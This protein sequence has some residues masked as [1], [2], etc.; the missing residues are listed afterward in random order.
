MAEDHSSGQTA[1]SLLKRWIKRCDDYHDHKC[2][3]VP[4]AE[5]PSWKVPD[6]V[7]DT[8]E[9]CIVA[10][11]SVAQYAALS[12]VWTSP[13]NE[14]G[15]ATSTPTPTPDRLMLRSDNLEDFKRSGFLSA[16]VVKTLPM[17]VRDALDLVQKSD[18]RYLWVDCLCIVQHTETTRDRVDAMSEIYSGATFTIIAATTEAGLSGPSPTGDPEDTDSI[19]IPRPWSS[20]HARELHGALLASHWATRGWTFQ[21]HLLSKRSIVFV[22]ETV[23]WAC[24]CSVWAPGTKAFEGSD[25]PKDNVGGLSEPGR[26][27][28][29]LLVLAEDNPR[30]D[31]DALP[32]FS[33]VLHFLARGF[34]GGFVC[35]LPVLFLD[36]AL[37][38]QP[39]RKAKR[40]LATDT[41]R[42]FAPSAPLPTWSWVG[43]KCLVDPGSLVSGLDYEVND[44]RDGK[45]FAP[46]SSLRTMNLVDWHA[47]SGQ[48]RR[49]EERLKE[50][51]FLERLK[52]LRH[53]LDAAML[54]E[55]W[56]SKSGLEYSCTK[57][58]FEQQAK[59]FRQEQNET[60][61]TEGFPEPPCRPTQWY[62]HETQRNT[63]YNY[64]L[65]VY[66]A[67]QMATSLNN[68][69]LLS[70]TTTVAYLSVR[71]TLICK[72][73]HRYD[74]SALEFFSGVFKK[75]K[76]SAM[77][78]R[79][80]VAT[81]VI[82][83]ANPEVE[84]CC[85]VITL[86][87]EQGQWAGLVRVMDDSTMVDAG[88]K[89]QLIA[90]SKGSSSR[91][92]AASTYEAVV[93]SH[94]CYSNRKNFHYHFVS[95]TNSQE[96]SAEEGN[97]ATLK[98][99]HSKRFRASQ[100]RLENK[101]SGL[102]L[103]PFYSASSS[104]ISLSNKTSSSLPLDWADETYSFYNV[105]WVETKDGFMYR[106]AAGRISEN[107][108]EQNCGN[109]QKITLG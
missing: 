10:G 6:W 102:D 97:D 77:V 74:S 18:V 92:E 75:K 109:S 46:R 4:I 8:R 24:Q 7:I 73:F 94:G 32:A 35:G 54:P 100:V 2:R 26:E 67:S 51:H 96:I 93:D 36:T 95:V 20:R 13:S 82:Y 31:K 87:D 80:P 50:H 38:W 48:D 1:A 85:P 61:G 76:S 9:S 107:I 86:E 83:K 81:S 72:D 68:A 101:E 106:K 66:D 103:G 33:G 65:P 58:A 98:H 41:G 37:L 5:R 69:A 39:L 70:C 55:G 53:D 84:D 59:Q 40:R 88:Q 108:W 14:S 44:I 3:V 71:R 17:V 78:A 64:P 16:D 63:L 52:D 15:P 89:I 47:I 105:L 43:W 49:S 28:P 91:L 79:Y 45:S 23:F 30:I 56:F 60:N 19:R 34:S 104:C 62:F 57:Q 11:D 25:G 21:E 42:N 99:R 12:Y 22:D 27:S 29:S 90:I